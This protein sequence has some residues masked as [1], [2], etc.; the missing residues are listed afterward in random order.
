MKKARL[1][2]VNRST[3]RILFGKNCSGKNYDRTGEEQ[4]PGEVRDGKRQGKGQG[5]FAM[6]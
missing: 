2:E 5:F 6:L 3:I 1:G 4:L